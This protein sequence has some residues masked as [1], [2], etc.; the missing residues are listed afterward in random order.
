MADWRRRFPDPVY[1]WDGTAIATLA[2]ARAW[3]IE[4]DSPRVEFQSAAGLLMA[5]ADGGDIAA[6]RRQIMMAAF[7]NMKLDVTKTKD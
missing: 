4:M 3:L 5:A 6:A 2:D 1:L 7:L